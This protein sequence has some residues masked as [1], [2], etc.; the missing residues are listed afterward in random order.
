MQAGSGSCMQSFAEGIPQRT[1]LAISTQ[2]ARSKLEIEGEGAATAAA[3]GVPQFSTNNDHDN[4]H[5]HQTH[6]SPWS[7]PPRQALRSSRGC[8]ELWGGGGSRRGGGG[9]GCGQS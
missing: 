9:G 5:H 7:S 2:R 3:P 1:Q 8:Y 4:N 6:L